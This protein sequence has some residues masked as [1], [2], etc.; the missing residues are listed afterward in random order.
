MPIP[1]V[2]QWKQQT[3]RGGKDRDNPLILDID[4]L[5]GHYWTPGKT[6]VQ[7]QK[8]LILILYYCTEWLCTKGEKPKSFRRP[9]IVQLE[10]AVEAELR[11]PAMIA[12]TDTRLGVGGQGKTLHE[13][14][15]EVLQPRDTAA[16]KYGL[17]AKVSTARLRAA[18]IANFTNNKFPAKKNATGHLAALQGGWKNNATPD[19]VDELKVLATAGQF[20]N[21]GLANLEYLSKTD[22]KQYKVLPWAADGLWRQGAS[23]TPY[24]TT[25]QTDTSNNRI[26][27]MYAMD[28]NELLY[29]HTAPTVKGT[30]HHS[31]F[32]SGKAVIC[33]GE[34]AIDNGV[35]THI[36]NCSGHYLPVTQHLIDC[37]RVLERKYGVNLQNITVM[38]MA[39]GHVWNSAT[40][41]L[42]SQGI[43]PPQAPAPVPAQA[44]AVPAPAQA[45]AP[46]A[47]NRT[48]WVMGV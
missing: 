18:G 26:K 31:S 21:L 15:N 30:F 8:I 27:D 25:T 1:T 48:P 36:D 10:A 22:R 14:A 16:A 32:L 20:K 3:S 5:L 42:N 43:P 33:A 45:A 17:Q 46:A 38:D 6:D 29:V 39:T 7:K 13:N 44:P 34:I 24:Q 9:H 11:S 37:V 4:V 41:F 35:I 12:A 23:I 47:R 19:Y 2:V 40:A 28:R